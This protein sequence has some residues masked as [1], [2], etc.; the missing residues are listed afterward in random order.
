MPPDYLFFKT[1]TGWGFLPYPFVFFPFPFLYASPSI[2]SVARRRRGQAASSPPPAAISPNPAQIPPPAASHH[3]VG[4]RKP[5]E[6]E[7]GGPEMGSALIAAR[8]R[9]GRGGGEGA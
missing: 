3:R 8:E 1:N 4:G 5:A 9:I 6:P 7:R 2:S